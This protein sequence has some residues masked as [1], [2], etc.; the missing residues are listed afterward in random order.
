MHFVPLLYVLAI[1]FK[2]WPY[3]ET[4]IALNFVLM[5]A[6]A[7]P[8]YKLALLNNGDRRFALFMATL[9]VWYPTFQ[10][11]VLYEF[12]M[13]RFSIPIILWM[14]YFWEKRKM[15]LY[16]SFAVLGVLVREEVGL[17]IMMFGLYLFFVE[18]RCRVGLATAFIGL[19][20]FA[21]ITQM[22]MPALMTSASQK[23]VV[24]VLFSDFGDS[25]SKI[26]ANIFKHPQ[27]FLTAFFHPIKLGNIF[28]LFLPLLFIPL[29]APTIL[30][31]I[32][33]NLGVGIL[34]RSLTHSSYMLYYVAPSIAFIFYAFIKGWPKLVM[35]LSSVVSKWR[36]GINADFN[37][38]AIVM[39]VS[40]LLVANVFFGASPLSLQFWFRDIRPAPFK[41]QNYHYSVYK[42]TEHHEKV[43]EFCKLIPDSAIVSAQQFLAPR[44]YRKRGTMVFPRLEAFNG[45]IEADYAFFDTT[46]N[47]LNKDS[48]AYITQEEFHL[49]QQDKERWKLIKSRDGFF[50]YRRIQK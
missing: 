18:R 3:N 22:V 37:S 6:A 29:F 16:F 38:V 23:L 13:L 7:I 5:I 14:L 21:I 27:L 48:P 46:N 42:V 30:I 40:G 10:Y 17:T 11:I 25:F 1:P 45:A 47:G 32:L 4:I 8:L 26:I 50:L 28:M 15:V 36:N 24:W 33:P 9:L 12:E 2:L 35:V 49:V 31:S 44:L 19:G 34:S 39:M 43:D 20:A 41:T